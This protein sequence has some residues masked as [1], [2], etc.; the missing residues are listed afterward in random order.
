MIKLKIGDKITLSSFE[1]IPAVTRLNGFIGYTKEHVDA[2]IY[3]VIVRN[4]DK[5]TK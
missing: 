3:T 1:N 5:K 2:T 4:N